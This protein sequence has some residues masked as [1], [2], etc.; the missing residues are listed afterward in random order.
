MVSA[1]GIVVA[2]LVSSTST[3]TSP[4][5]DR[6]SVPSGAPPEAARS[7][8]TP[9][10][11]PTEELTLDAA[12]AELERQSLTLAQARSRA[13][14]AAAAAGMTTAQLVPS[15]TVGAT[16]LRNSADARLDVSGLL[17]ALGRPPPAGAALPNTVIQ[18]LEQLSAQGSVR[19]PLVVPSA[20]YEVRAAR[21]GARAADAQA[22]AVRAQLRAGLAQ[23]AHGA[24]AAEEVV[25]ASE[26]A[27]EIAAEHAR[28]AE[29]SVAAGV[30]APLD[31][32]RAKTEQVRREGD[33][34]RARAELD[35]ARLALGILL[36]REAPVRV[37]VPDAVPAPG[38]GPD[39]ADALARRPEV[40]AQRE[41]V[42]AAQ[43]QVD[44]TWARLAPQVSATGTAFAANVPYPTGDKDGW[45]ATVDLTWPLFDG[46]L[47]EAR[48]RQAR[49]QLAGARAAEE[50]QRLAVVQDVADSTRDVAVARERLRLATTQRALAA[51]AAGSARRSF[52]AG[53]ASSLDVI[54]ANDRLYQA[55]VGLA[56]ARARLAQAAIG[57]DRALGLDR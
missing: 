5:D 47:R 52:E 20:W 31:A 42:D 32:L 4:T 57:L 29:R 50:A 3:S 45:R 10:P 23:A 49:A 16:Y 41:Q 55:D 26:R 53:V 13:E 48:R 22:A 39:P 46:G 36:G 54:D 25:I 19:V 24:R 33:L 8:G 51:D 34:V 43:A 30:A 44:A 1:V 17:A 27:L 18:P 35:R 56:D 6:P 38:A 21:S 15:V 11:T 12:L 37:A 14:D 2:V 40:R 9:T 7:R 28:S